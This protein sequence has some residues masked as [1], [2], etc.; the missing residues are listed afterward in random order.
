MALT[1]TQKLQAK[2][3]L[4][5]HPVATILDPLFS[6]LEDGAEK[7]TELVAAIALCETTE[8]AIDTV[9][10]E[11]DEIVEGGGAKFSYERRLAMKQRAYRKAVCD[12][13]R[14]IGYPV[15]ESGGLTGFL[16]V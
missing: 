7:E 2:R 16:S 11:A 1:A 10:T 14:I 3:H 15:P 13:G 4:G 6:V 9:T 5:E 8:T 12:L